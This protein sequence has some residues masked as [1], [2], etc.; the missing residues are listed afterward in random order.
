[1]AFDLMGPPDKRDGSADALLREQQRL[2]MDVTRALGLPVWPAVRNQAD[3]LLASGAARLRASADVVICTTDKDLLQCVRGTEVVLR[4]RIR[5]R[6][7]DEGVLF[8]RFGV[9]PTQIP[10][11]SALVGDP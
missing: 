10:T 8:E 6:T 5:S 9:R 11:R 7:T 3:D 2:A 4:D 1:M